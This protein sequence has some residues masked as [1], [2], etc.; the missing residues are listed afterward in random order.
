MSKITLI[1]LSNPAA[2]LTLPLGKKK[3]LFTGGIAQ[4]EEVP[5]PRRRAMT[6]FSGESLLK[7]GFDV[8]L[9]AFPDGDVEPMIRRVMGLLSIGGLPYQPTLIKASGPIVYP[10]VPYFLSKCDQLE[11]GMEHNAAGRVCRQFL[12]LEL[13]E[14]RA[15]DLV[16]QA[17][18]PAQ[19]AQQRAPDPP[20]QRTH[21][22]KAGDTLWAIATALLGKG[23]RW[24]EIADLNGV[25]DP[26]ALRIGQVLK[27]PN[28]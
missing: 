20:A 25:R 1:P 3:P 13:T 2:A 17:A 12:D 15:P 23:Q 16:V 8:V 5:R 9:N 14:Y 6:E 22:V 28:Q 21:T 18:A 24:Q 4:W 7:Y 11:D 26:R 19:A 10:D 27:I